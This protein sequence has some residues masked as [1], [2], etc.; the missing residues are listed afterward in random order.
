M[1]SVSSA[2]PSGV[3]EQEI[4]TQEIPV[5][6]VTPAKKERKS[7]LTGRPHDADHST[8]A[9]ECSSEF[10]HSLADRIKSGSGRPK[11]AKVTKATTPVGTATI[12]ALADT[13]AA[14]ITPGQGATE[15]Y[16]DS[17]NA[18]RNI[19]D[20]IPGAS[21]EQLQHVQ[22][23]T[24]A[25]TDSKAAASAASNALLSSVPMPEPKARKGVQKKQGKSV[26][27]ALSQVISELA[28][29][30]NV[31]EDVLQE[32]T[33]VRPYHSQQTLSPSADMVTCTVA[34]TTHGV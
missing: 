15:R 1:Q 5:S 20:G 22:E 31:S 10:S 9:V 28:P 29:Q 27:P 21:E 4:V 30:P 24:A 33:K 26:K 6:L 13:V 19:P 7:K 32:D 18:D 3:L 23:Q 16:L 14:M 2:Q 8:A 12:N 11:P 25:N 34:F 17:R